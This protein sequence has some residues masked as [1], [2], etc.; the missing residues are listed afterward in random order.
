ME[1][2]LI[3]FGT[4]PLA[5]RVKQALADQFEVFLAT[6]E[7]FPTILKSS[8]Y[9]IPKGVNPTF[10]HEVLKLALDLNIN[11]I[12]PL[13]Y[14][15]LAPF[16]ES[17]MLFEEYGIEILS[18]KREELPLVFLLENPSKDTKLNVYRNGRSLHKDGLTV[19]TSFSG[20]GL[21]SDDGDR[22]ALAICK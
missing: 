11:Y 1:K 7:E 4:R 15:E 2:I 21:V 16:A 5:Q 18:P 17:H 13:G 20:L 8:I 14:Q 22:I 10:A 9:S 12:L 19:S 3:T 6:S